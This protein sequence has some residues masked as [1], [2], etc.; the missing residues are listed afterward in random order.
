MRGATSAPSSI[1]STSP[2]A[3]SARPSRNSSRC[4]RTTARMEYSIVVAATASDPAPMQY[5]AP[6]SGCAMG[7]FFRDNGMAAVDLLRRPVQAGRR[8]SP[9]VAAASPP[10]WTRGLSGRRVLSPLA[11]PGARRQAQQGQRLGLADRAPGDRDAGQRRVGLYPDQRHLHHR[12][13]DLPRDRPVLSGHPACGERRVS[14]CRASA[15]P[16]R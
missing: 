5:L 10:A 3:R 9:D 7:E 12:R 8:L 4:S 1:A 6:F 16:R 13:S 15:P 11:A 14:R 2:S